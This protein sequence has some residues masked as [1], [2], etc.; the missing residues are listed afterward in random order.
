[1]VDRAEKYLD[2]PWYGNN[3][4]RYQAEVLNFLQQNSDAVA[5]EWAEIILHIVGVRGGTARSEHHLPVGVKGDAGRRAVVVA[6]AIVSELRAQP[7]PPTFSGIT[8]RFQDM[9]P[10]AA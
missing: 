6:D 3:Q 1:M 2:L 5:K 4:A 9:P 10:A 8:V 7:G